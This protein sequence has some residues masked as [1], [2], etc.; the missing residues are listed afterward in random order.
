MP[1]VVS[2]SSGLELRHTDT[3]VAPE[4]SVKFIAGRANR[5]GKL[6][7]RFVEINFTGG[8][9]AR[10]HWHDDTSGV[11]C[12]GYKLQESSDHPESMFYCV[13]DSS[14]ISNLPSQFS[15]HVHYILDGRDGCVEIA[16]T[17]YAWTEWDWPMGTTLEDALATEP[18][19]TG[20]GVG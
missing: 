20:T 9:F 10:V 19:A 18:F 17:G 15:N 1:W 5:D 13:L 8:A 12:L 16:A 7:Q 11:E 3:D 4:C 2:P 14:W 6:D